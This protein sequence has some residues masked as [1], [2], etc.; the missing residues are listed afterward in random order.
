MELQNR[1]DYHSNIKPILERLRTDPLFLLLSK[2]R[3][4]VVHQGMLEVLSKGSI[5]TTEGKGW[6]IGFPFPVHPTETSDEAYKR[7]KEICRTRPEV[8]SLMGPDCDSRPMLQRVW[9]LPDFPAQDF[10]EIA[11]SSWR[12]CGAIL[13]DILVQLGGAPLDLQLTCRHE[14]DKV[15]TKVFSQ[16][17]F[18]RTV[19][20]IDITTG[21]QI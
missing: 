18:F 10:L 9:L 1:P 15:R 12:A 3:D 7:F 2:K 4:F 11:V 19:D 20:G 17:D 13:S 5:G 6:K 8:R 21:K 14:P 16:G